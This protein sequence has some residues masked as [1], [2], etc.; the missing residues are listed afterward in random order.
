MY[1]IVGFHPM[2]MIVR[3]DEYGDQLWCLA[4]MRTHKQSKCAICSLPIGHE[5]Y[6]PFGNFSNRM[7]RIC[8]RHSGL[9]PPTGDGLA[10][11]A[12]ADDNFA[13]GVAFGVNEA[14]TNKGDEGEE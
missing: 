5:G 7:R 8:M 4:K 9:I 3:S 1:E 13:A 12:S 6:R 2:G 11:D 14:L 10:A